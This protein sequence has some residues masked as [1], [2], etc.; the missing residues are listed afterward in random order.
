MRGREVRRY[1]TEEGNVVGM[2]GEE[3]S[4][5]RSTHSEPSTPT[6]GFQGLTAI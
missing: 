6:V 2:K 3:G 4:H 5:N 1:H